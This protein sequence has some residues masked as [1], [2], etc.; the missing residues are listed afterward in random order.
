[1]SNWDKIFKP[2]VVLCVICIAITGALAVTN[3]AT[4]RKSVV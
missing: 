4:D 1:M 2:V 3:S